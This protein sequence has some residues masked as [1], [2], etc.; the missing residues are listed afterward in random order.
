MPY[1]DND[2]DLFD[3]ITLRVTRFKRNGKSPIDAELLLQK[4]CEYTI[5][6]EA[7]KGVKM[8]RPVLLDGDDLDTN[9]AGYFINLNDTTPSFPSSDDYFIVDNYEIVF[10]DSR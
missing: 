2:S 3:N 7:C 5:K 1:P 6:G 10:E 8:V 4:M 9:A